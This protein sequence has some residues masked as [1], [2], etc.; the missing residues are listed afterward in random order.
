MLNVIVAEKK[1]VADAISKAVGIN[2]KGFKGYIQCDNYTITWCS[3]HLL[4]MIEPH[5]YNP[6]LKDWNIQDLPFFFRD[7]KKKPID[8]TKEQFK[9]VLDLLKKADTVYHCGDPDDEGQLIVD[10]ILDY[11]KFN[12]QVKRVLINDNNPKLIQKAF[13][14]AKCNSQYRSLGYIALG[15]S[16]ADWHFGLNLTRAFT[17]LSKRKGISD[18][19]TVGRVQDAIKGLIVRRCRDIE[20]FI[21]KDFYVINS[22]LVSNT[23]I[24]KGRYLNTENEFLNGKLDD[25]NR[26]INVND[27][28]YIIQNIKNFPDFK[29]INITDDQKEK[30]PPLPYNLLKL[31]IDMSRKYGKALDETL[32]ITQSLRDKYNAITYNRSDCQ[33]LN[34]ET[35]SEAPLIL[36]KIAENSKMGAFEKIVNSADT[37]LKSKC[38]NSK[39]TSAHHAI[40]PTTDNFDISQLS[41]DEKNCYFLISRAFISQFFPKYKYTIKTIHLC[42]GK[43]D[44]F[45][46]TSK[47]VQD[48]GWMKLYKNDIDNEETQED[49]ELIELSTVLNIGDLLKAENTIFD[50][51]Q[52]TPPKYY[53]ESTLAGEL[54]RVARYIKSEELKKSMIEK[55]K[56]KEGEHG[57]IGTPATRGEILKNLKENG[58]FVLDGKYIKA[59]DKAYKL[60][61]SL[62]DKIKFPDLTALWHEDMKAIKTEEDA[63]LFCQSV[64]QEVDKIIEPLKAQ[65]KEIPSYNC[66]ECNKELNR[67]SKNS[68]HWWSCVGFKDKSCNYSCTDLDYKPT[69]EKP[70]KPTF[71]NKTF[72][73][74]RTK[75][76][77]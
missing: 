2:P 4:E 74:T 22:D 63:K 9:T 29:V 10:E 67:Y 72:K 5:E 21:K 39:K 15:R 40:I 71:E 51:K 54:T 57:G 68:N 18:L 53:T 17:T 42:N 43:G 66:P 19:I 3:G 44:N 64:I 32:A 28:E 35:H 34:D 56:G 7:I 14:D 16:Y 48:N 23:D 8:R 36:S 31:Q 30:A 1:L 33:Y 69:F 70:P 46:L 37:G 62:P 13:N 49:K 20:Q 59:T 12:K 60:Y 52:T 6:K 26:I 27:A 61:D 77:F 76:R 55:D 24:L 11:V 41:E 47:S 38:F 45:V 58:F 65:Y 50:I 25:E 75:R 73:K